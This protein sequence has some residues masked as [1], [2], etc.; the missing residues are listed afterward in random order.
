[1]GKPR[2][3][4]EAADPIVQKHQW[5]GTRA[6]TSSGDAWEASVQGRIYEEDGSC[7]ARAKKVKVPDEEEHPGGTRKWQKANNPIPSLWTRLN[8]PP[9]SLSS[10]V[11]LLSIKNPE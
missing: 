8:N 9:V 1:M 3:D 10:N 7:H 11:V 6:G 5:R 2:E 4:G